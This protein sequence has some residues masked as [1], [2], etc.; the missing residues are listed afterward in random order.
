MPKIWY[1]FQNLHKLN[2]VL[3]AIWTILFDFV[4]NVLNPENIVLFPK[5]EKN[6]YGIGNI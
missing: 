4:A 6:V 1:F 3:L 2:I 5:S